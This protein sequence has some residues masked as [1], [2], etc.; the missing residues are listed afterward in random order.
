VIRIW[1]LLGGVHSTALPEWLKES[2]EYAKVCSGT[3]R[4][5][6]G[7]FV[8]TLQSSGRRALGEGQ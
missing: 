3:S 7:A 6:S 4:E 8:F 2:V 5:P 1:E